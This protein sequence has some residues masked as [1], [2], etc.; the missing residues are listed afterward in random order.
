[1]GGSPKFEESQNLPDVDYA[2]FAAGLGL[3]A[4]TITDPD[5]L[6]P[7]WQEAF[8]ADRPYVLDIHCDPDIPPIPPHATAQQAID[9][10]AALVK[11]DTNR[12]GVIK[13]GLKTKAKEILPGR[14]SPG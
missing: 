1:M 4:R 5:E 6:G 11:G 3:H 14:G 8:R 13:E 2:G 10:A 9:A 7:A 12:F